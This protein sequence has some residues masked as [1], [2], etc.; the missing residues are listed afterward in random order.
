MNQIRI[1]LF[2]SRFSLR[3]T[4]LFSASISYNLLYI[5]CEARMKSSSKRFIDVEREREDVFLWI[6]TE[7]GFLNML[8]KTIKCKK[9]IQQQT[10]LFIAYSSIRMP[11][12]LLFILIYFFASLFL[13]TALVIICATSVLDLLLKKRRWKV[14][15][16]KTPDLLSRNEEEEERNPNLLFFSSCPWSKYNPCSALFVGRRV[17]EKKF[18]TTMRRTE[19]DPELLFTLK[20]APKSKINKP[21]SFR[22]EDNGI[23]MPL[24]R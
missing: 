2:A 7:F 21:H 11:R 8:K 18:M 17:R 12:Y 24:L 13:G 15:K 4:W 19:F 6:N 9:Y 20:N 3:S 23:R 14:T 5:A 1:S 22:F 16:K 10:A